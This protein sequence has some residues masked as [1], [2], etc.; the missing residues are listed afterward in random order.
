MVICHFCKRIVKDNENWL[1][2]FINS[3]R[4]GFLVLWYNGKSI[5]GTRKEKS[6][7][8]LIYANDI[9]FIKG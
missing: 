3:P 4:W 9:I 8:T 5:L 1:L 2:L 7:I 6:W